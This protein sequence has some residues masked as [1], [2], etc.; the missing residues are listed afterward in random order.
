[1]LVLRRRGRVR[2]CPTGCLARRP[3]STR[4]WHAVWSAPPSMS[5]AEAAARSTSRCAT[6]TGWASAAGGGGVVAAASPTENRTAT[7]RATPLPTGG[8]DQRCGPAGSPFVGAGHVDGELPAERPHELRPGD[9]HDDG[10]GVDDDLGGDVA[11]LERD[12]D[13]FPVGDLCGA[14]ASRRWRSAGP[15]CRR[16]ST[17]GSRRPRRASEGATCAVGAWSAS[18]A[19]GDAATGDGR[20]GAGDACRGTRAPGTRSRRA[21]VTVTVTEVPSTVTAPL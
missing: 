13:P 9:P 8:R 20:R 3:A 17:T 12:A 16:S 6:A 5:A 7:S 2:R 18:L 4:T 15:G 10:E 21:P 19:A 1:M 11:L 14:A